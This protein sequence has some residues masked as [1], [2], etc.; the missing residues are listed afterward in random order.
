MCDLHM[1]RFKERVYEKI[2]NIQYKELER[3][4]ASLILDEFDKRLNEDNFK[5]SDISIYEVKSGC[6]FCFRTKLLDK[7]NNTTQIAIKSAKES[8]IAWLIKEELIKDGID[9]AS[10]YVKGSSEFVNKRYVPAVY[11]FIDE[12]AYFFFTKIVIRKD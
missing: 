12:Y 6:Q 2:H 11:K 1:G 3:R 4:Y 8:N 5:P 10:V 7:A 9:V